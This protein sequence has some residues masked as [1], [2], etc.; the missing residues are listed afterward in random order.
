MAGKAPQKA[1]VKKVGK[2]LKEKREI[3]QTKKDE[4][5]KG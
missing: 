2:S 1:A 5:P 4:K 3:K